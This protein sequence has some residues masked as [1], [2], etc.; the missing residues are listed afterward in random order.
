MSSTNYSGLLKI[1]DETGLPGKHRF[2]EIEFVECDVTRNKGGDVAHIQMGMI[3]ANIARTERTTEDENGFK[4]FPWRDSN[5][6]SFKVAV[7]ERDEYGK[8]IPK[9]V[10]KP[11]RTKPE[12]VVRTVF[13]RLITKINSQE[14]VW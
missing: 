13:T 7:L 11:G 8:I 10:I 3:Y 1:L 12:T 2:F 4:K 6:D 9:T 14:I 5:Q